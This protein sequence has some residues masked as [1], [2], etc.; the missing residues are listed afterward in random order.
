MDNKYYQ[1]REY[2]NK[3]IEAQQAVIDKIEEKIKKLKA[4]EI[5]SLEEVEQ[6]M[7]LESNVALPTPTNRPKA[8]PNQYI[9]SQF[10]TPP[11]NRY[12]VGASAISMDFLNNASL[13]NIIHKSQSARGSGGFVLNS[14]QRGGFVN[15][16]C[17]NIS[18]PQQQQPQQPQQPHSPTP[19]PVIQIPKK[20]GVKKIEWY[21]KS[22]CFLDGSVVNIA[23]KNYFDY[24]RCEVH[25]TSKKHMLHFPSGTK[26]EDITS[27]P[28]VYCDNITVVE[29]DAKANEI[30][31]K[32]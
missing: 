6:K 4:A 12:A 21:Q 24:T 7:V 31:K 1:T 14:P 11:P 30:V 9:S 17:V 8:P 3:R 20:K 32:E 19:P 15:S 10:Q 16:R 23:Q 13:L 29:F 5:Q 25:T 27:C 22:E 2:I 28:I 18:L 26:P